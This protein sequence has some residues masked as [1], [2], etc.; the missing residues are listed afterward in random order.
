[1]RV[2]VALCFLLSHKGDL[3][4]HACLNIMQV[5]LNRH[6]WEPGGLY[7]VADN[8][9]EATSLLVFRTERSVSSATAAIYAGRNESAGIG[10]VDQAVSMTR[11][12]IG[13]EADVRHAHV[14]PWAASRWDHSPPPFRPSLRPSPLRHGPQPS[15]PD[16]I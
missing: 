4:H 5:M 11:L 2:S 8:E 3:E 13:F 7:E 10:S 9:G 12:L 6:R 1:M 14:A 15:C 16:P